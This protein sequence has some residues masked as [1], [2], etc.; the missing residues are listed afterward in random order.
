MSSQIISGKPNDHNSPDEN[1]EYEQS[2]QLIHQ[3]LQNDL[4]FDDVKNQVD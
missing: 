4:S 1:T 2:L 3:P